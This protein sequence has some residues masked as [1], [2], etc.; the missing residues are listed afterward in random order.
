MLVFS[1][2]LHELGHAWGALIQGIPVKR[3]KLY[4]GG[5]FCEAGRSVNRY[6]DELFTIC[7]PLVNLALWAISGIL[8]YAIWAYTP[9]TIAWNWL[10]GQLWYFGQINLILFALNLFPVKPLD[11]GR[12]FHLLLCR[13]MP[14][15][16][17]THIAGGVGLVVAVLWIPA[18]I[19]LYLTFGWMLLFIPPIR[20]NFIMLRYGVTG[21]ARPV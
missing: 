7:G 18:M 14:P 17:A 9:E 19:F 4:G 20:P 21:G 3:V 10:L 16:T 6:E 8:M 5:G 1:I 12:L 2:Y 11:G 15:R 13:L